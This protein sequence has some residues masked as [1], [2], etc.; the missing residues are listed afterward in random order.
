MK[1][2]NN[3]RGSAIVLVLSCIMILTVLG[4]VV[5]IGS[6]F[7]I[8]MG[9][10]YIDWSAEYY[11]LDSLADR[12]VMKVDTDYMLRAEQVA[13]EYI[14]KEYYTI[15]PDEPLIDLDDYNIVGTDSIHD[16]IGDAL[17][18]SI[19]NEWFL[20]DGAADGDE[21]ALGPDLEIFLPDLFKV[22]YYRTVYTTVNG[23]A[24]DVY[25]ADL[26]AEL[27]A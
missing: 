16:V 27:D 13:R 24:F 1:Y 17:Q 23:T 25:K 7:N 11:D 3:K 4:M 2:L 20:L 8:Q 21:E 9:T 19:Y 22:L 18:G 12:L 10:K 6:A 5:L 26:A 15:N 14:K